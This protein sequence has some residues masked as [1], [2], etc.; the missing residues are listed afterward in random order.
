MRRPLDRIAD[1]DQSFTWYYRV[2][3]YTN[4]GSVTGTEIAH[5]DVDLEAAHD[6]VMSLPNTKSSFVVGPFREGPV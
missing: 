3:G 1:Q 6:R 4:L 5:A 2:L